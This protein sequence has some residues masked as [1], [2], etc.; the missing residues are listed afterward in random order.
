MN[1]HDIYH[2]GLAKD[3]WS[4]SRW[5]VLHIDHAGVLLA[6]MAVG[7]RG[8]Y[9]LIDPSGVITESTSQEFI[10]ETPR[11]VEYESVQV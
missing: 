5:R 6:C 8:E 7:R 3:G 11:M 9:I 1:L 4:F 10:G 2:I